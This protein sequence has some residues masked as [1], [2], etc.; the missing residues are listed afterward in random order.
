MINNKTFT[1]AV[2]AVAISVMGYLAYQVYNQLKD[3]DYS[4]LDIE[5]DIDLE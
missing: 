4:M 2:F 5:E 3:I 1:F